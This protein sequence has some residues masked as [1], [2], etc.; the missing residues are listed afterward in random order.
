MRPR[1]KPHVTV[2]PQ[3]AQTV[4]VRGAGV[5]L[6]YSGE[7]V[8]ALLRLAP[9]LDGTRGLDELARASGLATEDVSDLVEGLRA[10]R[11]VEDAAQDEPLA[12]PVSAPQ[13]RAW[14]LLTHAPH[15]AQNRLASARILVLGVGD[16]AEHA[17]KALS[18][19]G[20]QHV[21]RAGDIAGQDHV[22]A[23][24]DAPDDAFADVN[25]RAIA[26][27]VPVTFVHA[28]GA[29][30][31][32]GPTLIPKQSACWRCY[33]LR[34]LGAH[35]NPERL[36]AARALSRP[37]E[38]RFPTFGAIAG[39]WAAQAVAVTVS[40]A[41]VPPLAG[42]V[43][44]VDMLSLQARRHRVLRIPRCPACAPGAVPDIDRYA[45]EPLGS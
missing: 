23:A 32:I 40:G 38:V 2:V 41:G 37:P 39:A 11:L 42:H 44:Q 26:A 45:L 43:S 7:A 30:V 29:E 8:P 12:A 4:L 17:A 22:L 10:D 14:S 35:P 15:R 6:R 13:R 24:A 9:L 28:D 36:L 16:I 27:D 5:F 19:L 20:A 33:T 25:A 1:L 34:S 31:I 18:A 3:D 21:A